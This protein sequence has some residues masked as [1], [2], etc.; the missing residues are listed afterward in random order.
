MIYDTDRYSSITPYHKKK[1]DLISSQDAVTAIQRKDTG[2]CSERQEP[3]INEERYS[4]KSIA[5]DTSQHPAQSISVFPIDYLRCPTASSNAP[6]KSLAALLNTVILRLAYLFGSSFEGWLSVMET[7]RVL[8]FAS[9]TS[10][11]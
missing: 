7:Y 6:T 3:Q 11:K 4:F 10:T 9:F 1:L 2:F 8:F 5:P